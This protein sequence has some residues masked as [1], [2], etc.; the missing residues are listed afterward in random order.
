MQRS[1]PPNS[2]GAREWASGLHKHTWV[3]YI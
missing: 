3:P 2:K 1:R